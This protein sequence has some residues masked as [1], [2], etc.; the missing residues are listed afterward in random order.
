[1]PDLQADIDE[2]V[3][4]GV[5]ELFSEDEVGERPNVAAK[6]RELEVSKDRLY[7]CLKGIGHHMT[8]KAACLKLSA[9]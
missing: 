5:R 4:K 3:A 9:I 1:M 2:L 6:A 7:C 8:R